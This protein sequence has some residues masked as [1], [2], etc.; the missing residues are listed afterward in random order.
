MAR[1]EDGETLQMGTGRVVPGAI[2]V[3]DLGA[4]DPAA[5]HQAPQGRGVQDAL[6]MRRIVE[7]ERH[8]A[9]CH[10]G[11]VQKIRG[12]VLGD[13]DPVGQDDLDRR[14]LEGDGAPDPRQ[15]GLGV[16]VARPDDE[17]G[18]ARR[19]RDAS[20]SWMRSNSASVWLWNSPAVPLE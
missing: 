15:G 17:A 2:A 3:A 4:R 9:G 20:A 19:Q 14:R 12:L 13:G 6:R 7:D 8:A 1:H 16:A 18:P 11:E 5:A 10:C